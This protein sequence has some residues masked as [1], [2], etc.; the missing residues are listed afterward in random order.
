MASPLAQLTVSAPGKLFLL[1]EHAVVYD[2]TCL[3]TAVD[4]RLRMNLTRRAST[5]PTL[6]ISAPDIGLQNWSIR[7][8]ALLQKNH[9]EGKSSF[10][11]SCVTLFFRRFLTTSTFNEDLF[12]E[13]HS[14]FDPKF[15]LGSSSATV[16]ACL[17]GLA[18]LYQFDLSATELFEMGLV[19]IQ[20]VQKLGSGA[21]LAAAIYG[22]TLYYANRPPR[23]ITP[24]ENVELPLLVVYSGEKAGTVNYVRQVEALKK[25]HPAV[26]DPIIETML[27]IVEAG[28]DALMTK[29]W[30]SF[31]ELMN[32]QHGLLHALGVDTPS[33]AE[34]VLTARQAGA[35]GA[36]LSGAGGGDCAIV[37]VD[38]AQ[39]S[40]VC[41]A[42]KVIGKHVLN[43]RVN[44]PG[45][46]VD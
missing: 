40:D 12:I 46:Q 44:A 33:L 38:E 34:I 7:L 22:G 15:G 42:M 2:G 28:R 1:G 6:H 18:Q 27:K 10:I 17:F 14:D 4:T 13:T 11:E 26:I 16:A 32:I 8:D 36:K 43:L 31:G 37:L 45:V 29:D 20:Q 24:L 19:A 23:Q 9:F 30:V 41:A 25:R 3:I 21:D 5:T 39:S 35:Y